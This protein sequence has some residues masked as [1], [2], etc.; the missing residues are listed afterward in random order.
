M[1]DNE[2]S[3]EY[4]E[5]IQ[6]N[7]IRHQLVPPNDHRRNIAEKII[8]VFKEHFISVLCGTDIF[9]NALV[10]QTPTSG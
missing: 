8:Q 2:Y 6:K 7:G 4:K 1:L 9:P 3:G 10:V 5:A